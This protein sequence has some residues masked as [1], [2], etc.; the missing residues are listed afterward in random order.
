MTD[1]ELG[2]K[3]LLSATDDGRHT[4]VPDTQK[5]P[6][7][8]M[9]K[10]WLSGRRLRMLLCC[11][12]SSFLIMLDSNIVA[13]SLPSIAR[14]LH[15]E[16]TDVEW[17]VSAYIL[18]FATLLMPAGALA[19]RLGRK[20]TLLAGLF[21]FT[22]ASL[23]CGLASNLAVLNG[24]RALQA[25]GAALQLS[26]AL[27]LIAH[28]FKDHERARVYAIWGTV[29]GL[30]PSFGPIVGGLVTSYMGW[31]WAFFINLPL[32]F[33]LVLLAVS[34]IDESRDPHARRL[35]LPGIV[36]FGTGLFSIVW[37]LIAANGV[38]WNSEAT[39]V[40]FGVGGLLLVAFVLAERLQSRPMVD[41]SLF[42]DR[43]FV[44]AAIA[45]FG[46]AGTAQVMMTVLPL[47]LQDAFGHS[48]AEAGLEM[49]PFALPLLIGPGIG[50]RLARRMSSRE[51]LTIGL[52]LVAAGNGATAAAVLA[53]FGYWAAALGMI[54]TGSG[55]GLL[56]SETTKAQLTAIPPERAGMASGIAGATRFVGITT[57][58][59]TLGAVLA[60][61]TE[62]NLQRLGT[63]SASTY[64]VDWHALSLEIVGGDAGGGLAALPAAIR[65]DIE[66]AIHSS[67][68]AGFGTTFAVAAAA[69]LISG[70]LTWLLITPQGSKVPTRVDETTTP[71]SP[72]H[73]VQQVQPASTMATIVVSAL[74]TDTGCG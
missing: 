12:G 73:H 58:V 14:D 11:A 4:T 20:R 23:L 64:I 53:G 9:A 66:A 6:H 56:N 50:G 21:V 46:Y 8:E 72:S 24:A 32:G 25:V 39:L 69:A 27:A 2:Q 51:I 63:T 16:F 70:T 34:S 71:S 22:I 68:A 38:G 33:G 61:V 3:E 17:V 26:A 30:A 28:G 19:D 48:P 67:V 49:I 74:K 35:D 7:G 29:M 5:Q 15:G 59:A 40:K 43:T 36:L 52:S 60:T 65:P 41:L 55:A 45:M 1:S 57:G 47:Y 13:V 44:G 10:H 31:R 42:G 54:I 37:A 62:N 18:P